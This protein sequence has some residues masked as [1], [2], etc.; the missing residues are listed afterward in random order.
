MRAPRRIAS[1]PAPTGKTRRRPLGSTRGRSP[2]REVAPR[3]AGPPR[4]TVDRAVQRSTALSRSR[5]AWSAEVRV[6]RIELVDRAGVQE[7]DRRHDARWEPTVQAQRQLQVLWQLE[8]GV[9]EADARTRATRG[10]AGLGLVDRIERRHVRRITEHDRLIAALAIGVPQP[11]V[12]WRAAEQSDPTA[13]EGGTIAREIV[14][15]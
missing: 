2:E 13:Q 7:V 3:R 6:A 4:G 10:H 8:P 14:V 9:E 11:A 15:D 12:R 1:A 5:T